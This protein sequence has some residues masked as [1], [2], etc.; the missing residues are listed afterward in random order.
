MVVFEPV[1]IEEILVWLEGKLIWKDIYPWIAT[2]WVLPFI[3]NPLLRCWSHK[4]HQT[5]LVVLR[6]DLYLIRS[7][8]E[9]IINYYNY[10]I[11]QKCLKSSL[12]NDFEIFFYYVDTNWQKNIISKMIF[13]FYQKFIIIGICIFFFGQNIHSYLMKW[14]LNK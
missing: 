6:Y 5:F 9:E 4:N 10:H 14:I 3:L 12:E 2:I 1:W 11:V 8:I 7:Y 13:Y